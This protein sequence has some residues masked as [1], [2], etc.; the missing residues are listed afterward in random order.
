MIE[1]CFVRSRSDD[2]R[3]SQTNELAKWL[4]VV[5]IF[6]E[7]DDPMCSLIADNLRVIDRC[8]PNIAIDFVL[9]QVI[10]KVNLEF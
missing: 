2:E 9:V 8:H 1:E 5:Y 4:K 10:R 7:L 3:V 6:R